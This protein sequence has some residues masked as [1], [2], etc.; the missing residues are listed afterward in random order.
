MET[1]DR[2]SDPVRSRMGRTRHFG[3]SAMIDIVAELLW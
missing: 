1:M 2:Q 3:H